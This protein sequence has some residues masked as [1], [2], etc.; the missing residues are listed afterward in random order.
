MDISRR[1]ELENKLEDLEQKYFILNMQ[2]KWNAEDYKFADEL[3]DKIKK[4]KE[5]MENE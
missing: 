3:K 1:I 5:E 2:D 4:V